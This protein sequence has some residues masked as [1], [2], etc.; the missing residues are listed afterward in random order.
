L[1]EVSEE[2]DYVVW[3]TLATVFDGVALSHL[4]DPETGLTMTERGIE[5]Y[6]GL[7]APPVFWPDLLRLRALVHSTAGRHE[8]GLELIDEAISIGGPDNLTNPEFLIIR[9]DVLS[10]FPDPDHEAAGESYRIAAEGAGAG[11]FHLVELQALTRLVGIRRQTGRSPDGSERLASLY[12]T[13]TE[14]LDEHDLVAAR[15]TLAS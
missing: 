13:F 1:A 14:G 6:S 10:S 3:R 4:G 5:L 12:A 9:G 2:N 11:G 8:R 7:T 15:E